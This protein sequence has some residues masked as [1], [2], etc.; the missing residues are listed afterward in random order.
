MIKKKLLLGYYLYGGKI[1][2][3]MTI[4]MSFD[5]ATKKQNKKKHYNN[6]CI[7]H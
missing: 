5:K 3:N 1:Q 2:V 6:N 7:E 4:L